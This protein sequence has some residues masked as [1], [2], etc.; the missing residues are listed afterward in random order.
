MHIQAQYVHIPYLHTN[1]IIH[2][3]TNWQAI[4]PMVRGGSS[5]IHADTCIYVHIHAYTYSVCIFFR[6]TYTCL[7][8][9]II[10]HIR[11]YTCKVKNGDLERVPKKMHVYCM[12]FDVYA[13][14]WFG[15][16]YVYWTYTR[17]LYVYDSID[18]PS[19]FPF[20]KYVKIRV[21]VQIPPLPGGRGK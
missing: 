4:G 9:V 6:S 13:R 19:N 14:I 21:Y 2:T 11:P 16:M 15:I 17:I 7:L 5:N 18:A 8:Y 12:Y 20:W 3:Y 10:L 1:T